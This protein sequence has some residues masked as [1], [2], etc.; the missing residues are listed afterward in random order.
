[1]D[2]RVI[3]ATN[4]DLRRAV[5]EGRFRQDLFY[6]LNVVDVHLPPLRERPEDLPLL[7]EHFIARSTQASKATRLSAEALR[8]L[9]N[10]P[11]PGNVREL[12]NTLERALVLCRGDEIT[13]VDLPTHLTESKPQVAGLQDALLRRYSLADLEREYITLALEFTE[14]K[15]KEAADLLGVDRKTL[16]RKLEEY[17]RTEDL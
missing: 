13:P 3:A 8:L 1:V 2:V 5:T 16:Y 7:I 6:R 14:G 15:K 10:Y 4:R 9:F 12:E 11:W 17:G